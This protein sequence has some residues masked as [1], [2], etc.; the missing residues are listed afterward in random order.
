MWHSRAASLAIV[1]AG[2]GMGL[3]VSD[4]NAV[5]FFRITPLYF[6]IDYPYKTNRGGGGG[7]YARSGGS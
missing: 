4:I 7:S 6:I 5:C 3:V 1:A 2:L